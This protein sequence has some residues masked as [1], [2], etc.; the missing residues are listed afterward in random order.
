MFTVKATY[1]GETRRLLF[2]DHNHFPSFDQ[3]F[4][5]L[6]RVFP[7]S[8]SNSY[9]LSSLFFSPDS[10]Q[11]SRMLIGSEVRSAEEYKQCLSQLEGRTWP[12]ALLRFSL[13]DDT[14]PK[15]SDPFGDTSQLVLPS[16]ETSLGD[17][18]G[19]C[20]RDVLQSSP[21]SA[22]NAQPSH[23]TP[24]I[25]LF[26]IPPP[27]IIFSSPP[28]AFTHKPMDIDITPVAAN[29]GSHPF[30]RP[31]QTDTPMPD[32]CC[33]VAQAKV[34]IQALLT[35]FQQ[36]LDRILT[37]T[38]GPE[39]VGTPT[40]NHRTL[41][42]SIPS[43]SSLFMPPMPQVLMC[44]S[45]AK[46][47]QGRWYACELCHYVMCVGCYD[48]GDPSYCFSTTGCHH[49]TR[50]DPDST[51]ESRNAPR[52]LPAVPM[53]PPSW[54][55]WAPPL[56]PPPPP[57][58]SLIQPF[59]PPNPVTPMIPFVPPQ[60]VFVPPRNLPE[61]P[62]LSAESNIH[63]AAD[64]IDSAPARVRT[65]PPPP[66]IHLGILCD[67][68]KNIIEGVRHKCLDCPDYDLCTLCIGGGGAE[69][70]NPFHE[71]F[72]I[73]Q[74]GRV[75][76]HTV[77]SGDREIESPSTQPV[78]SPALPQPPR[79]NPPPEPA[80]H[81]AAC[82][83]CDSR[84][85]G[86]RYK[87]MRCPDFDT[88][89]SCFRIVAE[90]HPHHS[91]VKIS[92]PTDLVRP[93]TSPAPLHFATC[94]ACNHPIRGAR[95]KCLHPECPD[96][97]LCEACEAHPIPMHPDNHPLLKMKS[98]DTVIP[99]V[100]RVGQTA[101]IDH[102]EVERGR[103]R[104]PVPRLRSLSPQPFDH[105]YMRNPR[106][107]RAADSSIPRVPSPTS[108]SPFYY[109]SNS[110][111]SSQGYRSRSPPYVCGFRRSSSPPY[112]QSSSRPRS[113]SHSRSRSPYRSR[114]ASYSEAAV[115]SRT[116]PAELGS[117]MTR[118]NPNAGDWINSS[119]FRTLA[120][121]T[122]SPQGSDR[123]FFARSPH[124]YWNPISPEF[125]QRALTPTRASSPE[126]V[127]SL[128]HP[129]SLGM[130]RFDPNTWTP[131]CQIPIPPDVS[132]LTPVPV[133]TVPAVNDDAVS[134]ASE[135]VA[136]DRG[137]ATPTFTNLC[138]GS[139][140]HLLQE[141]LSVSTIHEMVASA[142]ERM[143]VHS[144]SSPGDMMAVTESPITGEALL[145]RPAG[146]DMK[147]GMNATRRS[148]AALLSSYQT[149]SR[150]AST[151]VESIVVSTESN[152]TTP[153]V[154]A[155]EITRKPTPPSAPPVKLSANFIADV[156]VPDG[157][158]FPPGAEFV[159][160]WRM[161]N[162]SDTDWPETTELVFV[163]GEALSRDGEKM[164]PVKVGVVKNGADVDLWTGELKA[165]DTPGRYVGY[166]R[167]R[168]EGNLFGNSIWIDITVAETTHHLSSGSESMSSS[169]IIMPHSAPERSATAPS[170]TS[171][172]TTREQI[173]IGTIQDT[174]DESTTLNS[175]V[176]AL[177]G[178]S[179]E[180]G[181][182][183]AASDM[184]S[185]SLLSMPSS[186]GDEEAWRES[187]VVVPSATASAPTSSGTPS[188]SLDFVL[189]YDDASSEEG[190]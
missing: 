114:L 54:P 168:N 3:L 140:S 2:P 14:S 158:V 104:S 172:R 70:H 135:N 145:N 131:P 112:S 180:D 21:Q 39:F 121:R 66:P 181:F 157:Q 18:S 46:W 79:S 29:L 153:T 5:Q 88:C 26:H 175:P 187:R 108:P 60:S 55:S 101:I 111:P 130:V 188:A 24:P 110:R 42:H 59:F 75:I 32:D 36:D 23:L 50:H 62:R 147:E 179:S 93:S 127:T 53:S 67:L 57:F 120:R 33:S 95:F 105:G 123:S 185:V 107:A 28:R 76:V 162:D 170:I 125:Q 115:P 73:A 80:V 137:I 139:T 96:Y 167:L 92:N 102:P 122:P 74:P 144:R 44:S 31:Q 171:I 156:T 52:A 83:L 16:S 58:N 27:P 190:L 103:S 7:V 143:P 10:N 34:E 84:I 37:R 65:P 117:E 177:S 148:L 184:S 47:F 68:C 48:R 142:L 85:A 51:T 113:Q 118:L 183:D 61:P 126:S 8:I 154:R 71:F 98:P 12:N 72:E 30:T 146:P 41:G 182:D 25:S 78:Q 17:P 81:H 116:Q 22:I 160:C 43:T 77:F 178:P 163:A 63:P 141:P 132:D 9:A 155:D 15:N 109:G 91:F 94:D 173:Q 186:L 100:Y 90:H 86:D 128:P 11:L 166:W 56:P 149:A 89:A 174:D 35:H 159:K 49:M 45:C 6:Y 134:Q 129:P 169:L 40:Q 136:A 87:C 176:T 106:R 124:I 13:V 20:S 150:C 151:S 165:P 4:S 161:S 133:P 69:R 164:K 138:A 1:R 152:E 99:T 97:D 189:L 82:D 119:H 38:F 64:T 19:L